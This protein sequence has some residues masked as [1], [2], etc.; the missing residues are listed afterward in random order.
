ME[1]F[2][3]QEFIGDIIIFFFYMFR[4][5]IKLIVV[6]YDPNDKYCMPKKKNMRIGKKAFGLVNT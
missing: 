6:S 1:Y 2:Q 3:D 5:S 4:C